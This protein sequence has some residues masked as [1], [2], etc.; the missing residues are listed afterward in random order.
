MATTQSDAAPTRGPVRAALPSILLF[1]FLSVATAFT[2]SASLAGLATKLTGQSAVEHLDLGGVGDLLDDSWVIIALTVATLVLNIVTIVIRER[3]TAD[4]DS[5][6]R[7][8]LITSYAEA[9]FSRQNDTSG[10]TL[11]VVGE[12][13]STATGMLMSLIGLI[14]SAAKALVFVGVSFVTSWQVSLVCIVTGTVLVLSF[15]LLTRRTRQ[16]NK[17]LA[18]RYLEIGEI[19]GDMALGARE[20]HLL[21]RWKDAT[22]RMTG[23]MLAV[24]H[25]RMRSR[26]LSS[27]IAP[28]YIAGITVIGLL[29]A[30]VAETTDVGKTAQL[31][32]SG[33]LLLRALGAVQTTQ[34]NYQSYNDTRPYYDQVMDFIGGLHASRRSGVATLDRPPTSLTM[35]DA[36]ISYNNEAILAGLDLTVQGPGGVALVG[37]SGAGK[38]TLLIALAGLLPPDSGEVVLDGES[39]T[40]LDRRE[41]GR[42]VGLLPQDSRIIRATLRE[43]LRRPDSTATDEDTLQALDAVDLTATVGQLT[44]GLD[45]FMGRGGEGFSGGELQRLGLARLMLSRPAVWLLDEPTSALDRANS[46]RAVRI[47]T[48]AMRNHLVVV[49]THRPEILKHC[50][51]VVLVESGAIVD[52][53]P[54]DEVIARQPFVAAM[55]ATTH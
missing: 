36:T 23:E 49:V 9:D 22:K 39:L 27:L 50:D 17:I 1:A 24:R 13:I 7:I 18:R 14:G 46:D 41:L 37:P 42:A 31:A 52:D 34:V 29:V 33:L 11:A 54:L 16:M 32:A 6:R 45:S 38:S 26:I 25:L 44:T 40:S 21:D 47:I 10:S 4:W 19:V 28:L 53:G 3:I 15:R 43:N 35:R 51:R 5:D 48:E 30:I 8:E 55:T 12:Q 20:M 2:E